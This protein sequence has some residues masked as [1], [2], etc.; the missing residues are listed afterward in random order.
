MSEGGRA[1]EEQV[2]AYQGQIPLQ[3]ALEEL[4]STP[5]F[6]WQPEPYPTAL[7]YLAVGISGLV[8]EPCAG[9]IK[10]CHGHDYCDATHHGSRQSHLPALGRKDL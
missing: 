6:P 9:H 3:A 8:I 7:P 1:E 5:S 10:G 4:L 2:R